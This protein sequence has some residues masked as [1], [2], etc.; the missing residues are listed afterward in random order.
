M[1]ANLAFSGDKVVEEEINDVTG[2]LVDAV[3]VDMMYTLC[4]SNMS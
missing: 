4:L 2:K 3:L 1:D